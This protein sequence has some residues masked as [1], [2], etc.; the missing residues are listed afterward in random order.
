MQKL[1]EAH[2]EGMTA[3]EA[4]ARIGVDPNAT[5]INERIKQLVE[6]MASSTT[7]QAAAEVRKARK[8]AIEETVK[9]LTLTI[10]VQLSENGVNRANRR[11]FIAVRAKEIR[12]RAETVIADSAK[13][14]LEQA[15]DLRSHRGSLAE[16]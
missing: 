10:D 15:G 16:A 11:R 5:E 1:T 3:E 8:D 6:R 12:K 13:L 9:H 4:V 7:E 2:A 14:F